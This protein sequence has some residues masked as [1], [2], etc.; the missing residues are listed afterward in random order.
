MRT[1]RS[2]GTVGP[3]RSLVAVLAAL[4]LT[5]TACGSGEDGDGGDG[6][7]SAAVTLENISF[8]PAD[9]E[10]DAGTTVTF[11]NEDAVAHTVTAGTPDAPGDAF[12]DELGSEGASTTITFDEAG[13][14]EL[15]CRFHPQMTGTITVG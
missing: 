14:V 8:Q 7:G 6:G 15:Y 4:L 3:T 11:T 12:D 1:S 2:S 10:V 5:L 9:L 13:T